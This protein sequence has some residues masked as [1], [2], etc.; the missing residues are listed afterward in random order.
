[1]KTEFKSV[2]ATLASLKKNNFSQRQS[3]GRAGGV[4]Q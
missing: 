2:F 3:M 1:M 4:A